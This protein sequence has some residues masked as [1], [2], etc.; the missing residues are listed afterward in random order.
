[1]FGWQSPAHTRNKPYNMP[2]IHHSL[3]NIFY[4][5]III[6]LFSK[7]YFS[8]YFSELKIWLKIWKNDYFKVV[9]TYKRL[10]IECKCVPSRDRNPLWFC[11]IVAYNNCTDVTV[12]HVRLS[13][14]QL[15]DT[16]VIHLRWCV[17]DWHVVAILKGSSNT[18]STSS[19]QKNFVWNL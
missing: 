19:K 10:K 11:S 3:C 4:F 17:D 5:V 16:N 6:Y 15:T 14:P 13:L 9:N 18:G 12:S 8:G 2:L 7:C 1:M